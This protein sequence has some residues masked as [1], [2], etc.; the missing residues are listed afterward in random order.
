MPREE[1]SYPDDWFALARKEYLRSQRLLEMDDFD[2][3]LKE[4][5]EIK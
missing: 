1:S 5:I 3:A 4:L 2:G